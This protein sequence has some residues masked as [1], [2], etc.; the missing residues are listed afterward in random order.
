MITPVYLYGQESDCVYELKSITDDFLKDN[1]K[2]Q[3]YIWSDS[4]KEAFVLLRSGEYVYIKKWAC[5]HYSTE[6]KKVI[7]NND[8]EIK[9]FSKDRIKKEILNLGKP[10]LNSEDCNDLEKYISSQYDSIYEKI[11]AKTKCIIII[12]QD[13]YPY[14]SITVL[15]T[16]GALILSYYY[17]QD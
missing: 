9:F 12:P 3:S 7:L 2:I 13:T 10:F 16:E 8:K 14:F 4:T 11:I 17:Y 15:R 1:P 5:I 6:V